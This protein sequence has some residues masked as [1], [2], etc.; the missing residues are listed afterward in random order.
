MANQKKPED[1]LDDF[2][3]EISSGLADLESTSDFA[4]R[5][6]DSVQDSLNKNGFQNLG[7]LIS[8]SVDS[9]VRYVSPSAMNSGF[10]KPEKINDGFSFVQNELSSIRYDMRRR[11]AFRDGHQEALRVYFAQMQDA[12]KNLQTFVDIIRADLKERKKN[13]SRRDRFG[14][15]YI[16]GLEDL[17]RILKAEKKFMMQKVRNDLINHPVK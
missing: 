16:A 17:L 1:F 11:G 15:G 13:M 4:K 5:M 9:A 12:K 3:N 6:K 2:F 7:D 8:Q 14:E 10:D